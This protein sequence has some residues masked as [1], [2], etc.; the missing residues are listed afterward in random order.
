MLHDGGVAYTEVP[1]AEYIVDNLSVV[2][3]HYP[4]VHY[5]RQAEIAALFRRASFEIVETVSVKGSHDVGFFVRPI[6]VAP[7]LSY[8]GK[9]F[10]PSAVKSRR[11]A[12]QG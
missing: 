3:F 11:T 2:D 8:D 1:Y 5:Y 12:R 7:D 4:H 10:R 6:A 9:A